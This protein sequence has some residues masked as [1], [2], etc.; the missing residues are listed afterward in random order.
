M[1][2]LTDENASL[3]ILGSRAGSDEFSSILKVYIVALYILNLV[4]ICIIHVTELV[5]KESICN[6]MSPVC[7]IFNLFLMKY[8][9]Y[10]N[11]KQKSF[12]VICPFLP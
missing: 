7:K 8:L 10:S 4:F 12:R 1:K 3:T 9:I 11:G 5:K 2:Q 6:F